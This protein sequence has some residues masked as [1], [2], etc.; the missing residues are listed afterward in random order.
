MVV[1]AVLTLGIIRAFIVEVEARLCQNRNSFF[2][3][4][5]KAI[6]SL[7]KE[8]FVVNNFIVIKKNYGIKTKNRS[9]H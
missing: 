7:F 4:F 8:L 6:H 2:S 3:K 1:P 5:S 9:N